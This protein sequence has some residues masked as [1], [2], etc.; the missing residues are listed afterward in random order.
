LAAQTKDLTR[1]REA[2]KEHDQLIRKSAA[3][4]KRVETL[5]SEVETMK[6][7]KVKLQNQL[8]EE[9]TKFRETDAKRMKEILQL[10]KEGRKKEVQ[11]RALES[12]E[13]LKDQILKRKMEEVSALKKQNKS[14]FSRRAGG[15]LQSVPVHKRQSPA[16]AKKKW[17]ELQSAFEKRASDRRQMEQMELEMLTHIQ[18]RKKALDEIDQLEAQIRSGNY[19]VDEVNRFGDQI[20]SLRAA[21]EYSDDR[22]SQSQRDICELASGSPKTDEQIP[23]ISLAMEHFTKE[24]CE[25]LMQKM[26][27]FTME[28]VGEYKQTA[29]KL[30]IAEEQVNSV[31]SFSGL[32]L[33]FTLRKWIDGFLSFWNS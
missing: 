30:S 29:A 23:D 3:T 12:K 20:D 25:Y 2:L 32:Y 31:S 17:A 14:V 19:P 4:E 22:I 8:R 7:L 1:L 16:K 24:D 33:N 15:R 26:Y 18:T 13:K 6:K 5:K 21:L 28:N 11:I 9:N 27:E 10:K